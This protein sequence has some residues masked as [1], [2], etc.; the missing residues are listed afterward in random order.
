MIH[1]PWA[2]K[3]IC[4]CPIYCQPLNHRAIYS[5]WA[6]VP[7]F[8]AGNCVLFGRGAVLTYQTYH[9]MIQCSSVLRTQRQWA[10]RMNLS[11]IAYWF[12]EGNHEINCQ[13]SQPDVIW[14]PSLPCLFFDLLF[15]DSWID[16]L[17]QTTP[18]L[19]TGCL[20]Q[21]VRNVGCNPQ[22]FYF[23]CAQHSKIFNWKSQY[24][25]DIWFIK[26]PRYPTKHCP[27]WW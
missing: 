24:T 23:S 22:L 9:R 7:Q 12:Q 4:C 5:L 8:S 2:I 18:M 13:T 15:S 21:K 17:K 25:I 1:S 26:Q 10:I 14:Y 19:I 20:P 27:C 11:Q 6:P 3:P 16:V